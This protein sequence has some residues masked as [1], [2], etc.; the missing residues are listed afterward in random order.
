MLNDFPGLSSFLYFGAGLSPSFLYAGL[1]PSRLYLDSGLPPSLLND[2]P[3]LS[4]FLYFGAG[5][6]PSLFIVDSGLSLPSL[7][8]E[9]FLS[10]PRPIVLC[11]NSEVLSNLL[12]CF[13][14]STITPL[15]IDFGI[16]EILS[17]FSNC[18]I[19][20]ISFSV[21]ID[22]ATPS[23]PF[24]PVLPALC[25]YSMDLSG[26][27]TLNICVTPSMSRP[28]A[29]MSEAI[30]NCSLPDLKSSIVFF[31]SLFMLEP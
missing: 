24:R 16:M 9:F 28:L 11:S 27:L 18:F 3:G 17:S 10:L 20:G 21:A 13:L 2:F 4:S 14:Y 22:I 6:S 25:R 7:S 5:L 26:I 19:R 30:S 1:S 15:Y 8:A 23:F 29:A 31:L 12:F